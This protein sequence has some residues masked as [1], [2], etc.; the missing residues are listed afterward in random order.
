MMA[1]HAVPVH[2]K[3][4]ARLHHCE[5]KKREVSAEVAMYKPKVFNSMLSSAD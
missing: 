3:S 1:R 5:E 4:N 2:V